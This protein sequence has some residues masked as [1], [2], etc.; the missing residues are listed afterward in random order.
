[1]T[2]YLQQVAGATK[3]SSDVGVRLVLRHRY[4]Y[5]LSTTSDVI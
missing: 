1:L 3:V 5:R 2:K 4:A